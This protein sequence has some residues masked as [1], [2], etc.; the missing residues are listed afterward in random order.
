MERDTTNKGALWINTKKTMRTQPDFTGKLDVGGVEYRIA[1]WNYDSNNPSAP[2][3]NIQI[4]PM[5]EVRRIAAQRKDATPA[6][7]NFDDFD[8]DIPF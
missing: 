1:M 2:E 8:D 5:D 3:F 7:S 4:T 6:P